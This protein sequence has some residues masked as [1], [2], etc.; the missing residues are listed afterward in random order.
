MFDLAINGSGTYNILQKIQKWF[1][2]HYTSPKR[3]Y[4][5]FTRKW[6]A[7][8]AFYQMNREEVLDRAK[9]D[10]GIEPGNPGFLGAL[11]V[12]TTSLWNA[13][14]SADQDDY[15]QAAVEWSEKSPPRYI[16]SRYVGIHAYVCSPFQ[17]SSNYCCQ[18]GWQ[19]PCESG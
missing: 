15:V 8:N 2:N 4:T 19:L 11:Q 16:Q 5:K 13:L 14:S 9:E 1:Y 18:I 6:S 7:R 10:S 17:G 12:A 3:H